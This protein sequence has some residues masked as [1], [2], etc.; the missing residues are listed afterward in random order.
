MSPKEEPRRIF[1]RFTLKED[2]GRELD[3]H[4]ELCVE[5]LVR[6]GWDPQDARREASRRFG[7]RTTIA[8]ECE[9]ISRGHQRAV[10]RESMMESLSQDV[11]YAI[12]ALVRSPGLPCSPS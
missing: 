11:R 3:A 10:R 2:V 5:E 1:R 12:R 8:R 9:R 6:D 4:V 7:D